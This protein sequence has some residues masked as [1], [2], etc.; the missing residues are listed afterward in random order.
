MKR[1]LLL[2]IATIAVAAQRAKA[3]AEIQVIQVKRNIPLSDQEPVY[4]DYYLSGGLKSG[5]RVNLVVPV[6]R[7]INLRENTQ[8]QDQSMK[9]LEPVGWLKVIFTQDQL[10]VARLYASSDF[11]EQPV[12][13]LPGIMMGDVISLENSY[14]PKSSHKAPKDSLQVIEPKEEA[15]LRSP[16]SEGAPPEENK[17][18]P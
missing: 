7:W 14:I 9:I 17:P 11:S 12:L 1:I 2:S 10:A 3:S 13:D 8:A 15:S 16:S 4:K 18:V 5:L 6:F